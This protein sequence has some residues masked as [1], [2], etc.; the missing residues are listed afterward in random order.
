MGA[1]S[2]SCKERPWRVLENARES[3]VASNV[4]SSNA[5][6]LSAKHAIARPSVQGRASESFDAGVLIHMDAAEF[7]ASVESLQ[8]PCNY[9]PCR[10][11]ASQTGIVR[12]GGLTVKRVLPGMG[13]PSTSSLSTL[14]CYFGPLFYTIG[15]WEPPSQNDC[16]NALDFLSCFRRGTLRRCS[17]G[18][19]TRQFPRSGAKRGMLDTRDTACSLRLSDG[20]GH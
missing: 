5:L 4:S 8:I 10:R 16:G 13:H 17:K 3:C 14:D 18:C 12:T 20:E 11:W 1:G 19:T 6:S 15:I 2:R 9:P 7:S